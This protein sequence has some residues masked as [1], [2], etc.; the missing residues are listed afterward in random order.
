MII[1]HIYIYTPYFDHWHICVPSP[2]KRIEMW[3][4]SSLIDYSICFYVRTPHCIWRRYTNK[5]KMKWLCNVSMSGHGFLQRMMHL[6]GTNGEIHQKNNTIG[7]YIATK[8]RKD[9]ETCPHH[10]SCNHWGWVKSICVCL[11]GRDIATGHM[12]FV[13]EDLNLYLPKRRVSCYHTGQ[14]LSISG[15]H[16]DL[17]PGYMISS[18][19]SCGNI[20][21]I[22]NIWRFPQMGLPHYPK[23]SKLGPFRIEPMVSGINY[24][25]LETPY[26]SLFLLYSWALHFLGSICGDFSWPFG[27]LPLSLTYHGGSPQFPYVCSIF[28]GI[29]GLFSQQSLRNH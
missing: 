28:L 15:V 1:A 4:P 3:I 21:N 5:L 8:P 23:L 29:M 27:F 22:R 24:P 11:R 7:I 14:V 13:A 18:P 12:V 6:S 26:H 9:M 16:S 20:R 25:F 10:L 2:K 19:S 17:T